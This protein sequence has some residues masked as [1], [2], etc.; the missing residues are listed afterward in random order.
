MDTPM[1]TSP[2]PFSTTSSFSTVA[3]GSKSVAALAVMSGRFD[4]EDFTLTKPPASTFATLPT[5]PSPMRD[6]VSFVS[7]TTASPSAPWKLLRLNSVLGAGSG[8]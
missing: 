8:P 2:V 3:S 5:T 4:T 1:L 7:S 6:D